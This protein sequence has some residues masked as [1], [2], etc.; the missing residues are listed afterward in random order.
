MFSETSRDKVPVNNPDLHRLRTLFVLE[1]QYRHVQHNRYMYTEVQYEIILTPLLYLALLV[2]MLPNC[3]HT[4][5][6]HSWYFRMVLI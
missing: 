6:Q 2:L 3:I 1:T 5:I 4:V